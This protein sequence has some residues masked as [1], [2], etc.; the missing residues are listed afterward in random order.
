MLHDIFVC[1]AFCA[2]L[3]V[4]CAAAMRNTPNEEDV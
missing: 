1:L 2:I 4:P 3:F